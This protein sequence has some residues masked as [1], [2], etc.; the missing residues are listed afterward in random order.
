MKC[1]QVVILFYIQD[2]I[3]ICKFSSSINHLRTINRV[4]N[5]FAY[6]HME[7]F[8][9]PIIHRDLKTTQNY[10]AGFDEERKRE[11]IRRVTEI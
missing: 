10:F 9:K 1:L 5:Y 8:S 2:Y 4:K 7:Y 3:Q 11:I 6:S